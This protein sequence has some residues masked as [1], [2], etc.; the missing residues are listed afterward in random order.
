MPAQLL[1]HLHAESSECKVSKLAEMSGGLDT[2]GCVRACVRACRRLLL[3]SCHPTVSE[4][5]PCNHCCPRPGIPMLL[6][7]FLENVDQRFKPMPMHSRVG[8]HF[9]TPIR[10]SHIVQWPLLMIET[11]TRVRSGIGAYCVI[12]GKIV[13]RLI[14]PS[15]AYMLQAKNGFFFLDTKMYRR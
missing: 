11:A 5:Q 2:I 7:T 10:S 8:L 3:L 9:H 6:L 15:E 14:Y 13:L 1:G 12:R 4:L